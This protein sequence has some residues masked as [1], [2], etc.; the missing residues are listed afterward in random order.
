M[1]RHKLAAAFEQIIIRHRP[2]AHIGILCQY[3]HFP[4][5]ACEQK[6]EYGLFV[7]QGDEQFPLHPIRRARVGR[8]H[9]DER[10]APVQPIDNR[11]PSTD[12][13]FNADAVYPN[14]KT[15]RLQI[16]RECI[17]IRAVVFAIT[18]ENV[19]HENNFR[20]VE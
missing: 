12:A 19:A 16:I 3:E 1:R 7:L 8:H 4:I 11:I 5:V 10:A 9:H 20:C 6:G 15:L 2:I 14:I 18:D 13:I 17:R